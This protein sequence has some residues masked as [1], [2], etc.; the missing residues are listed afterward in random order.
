MIYLD[1]NATAPL[2]AEVRDA[3]L[4]WFSGANGA[5]T[6]NASS[7]HSAGRRARSAIDDARTHVA[8]LINADP[9][10]IHFC[11][12]GTE[13]D[14]WAL[15]GAIEGH[16]EGHAAVMYSAVEHPAIR[17]TAEYF[18]RSGLTVRSIGV[19]EYGRLLGFEVAPGTAVVAVMAAN[20]EVGNRYD[21]AAVA[22]T[23]HA[24]G[25]WC[26]TDLVQAAGKI[27][28]D[29]TAWQADTAALSAHK[30]GGPQGVG[31]L[32]IRPGLD[33]PPL[34]TGGGQ[35]RGLRSGTENVAGIVGF[36][37]AARIALADLAQNATRMARL[38]DA[39]ATNLLA[40][41]PDA[42]QLGD[43]ADRLPNTLSLAIPNIAGEALVMRLD[44]AEIAVST[45]S[46]CSS[47]S[48]KSSAVLLAMG[49][50]KWQIKGALRISLGPST[51]E[52]QTR[53]AADAIAT[54]ARAL[55]ALS[56]G[57]HVHA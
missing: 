3:M 9:A 8:A 18:A 23:A 25:A 40:A 14:V 38:R 53:T 21:I 29:I 24:A 33:L 54:A 11:S 46:A 32:Y 52:E 57:L 43:P 39:M 16:P 12:G 26:H 35:E 45:G 7:L 50:P 44:A 15:R 27:P 1:H 22:T 48:G 19:D 34:I 4:P 5:I 37:V 36:G 6:G 41:L 47:G 10:S 17:E 51:T 2:L 56:E 30:I 42:V 31:A 20:N 13:A 49:L 28:V 55:Q